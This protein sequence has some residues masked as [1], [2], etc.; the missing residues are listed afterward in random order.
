MS[1]VW[2]RIRCMNEASVKFTC[3]LLEW[4][5]PI[6]SCYRFALASACTDV[7]RMHGGDEWLLPSMLKLTY[8]NELDADAILVGEGGFV[9]M[10]AMLLMFEAHA[11]STF[12]FEL[13]PHS[14]DAKTNIYNCPPIK[15]CTYTAG[16]HQ[17]N[18]T[19]CVMSLQP[20][21]QIREIIFHTNTHELHEIR[22]HCSD[23]SHKKIG[24]NWFYYI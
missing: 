11:A 4:D 14:Q 1:V 9:W 24:I 20:K 13:R 18:Y 6:N 10:W 12:R 23:R 21:G 5:D 19:S 15:S 3:S 8:L 17:R 22:T 16:K 2:N 7:R